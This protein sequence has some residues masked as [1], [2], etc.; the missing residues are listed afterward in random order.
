MKTKFFHLSTSDFQSFSVRNPCMCVCVCF[1]ALP[2]IWTVPF[3]QKTRR[4]SQ[5]TFPPRAEKLA[6]FL[7]VTDIE[8]D[9]FLSMQ[10]Q[11][12]FTDKGFSK[13]SGAHAVLSFLDSCLF[14]TQCRL[15]E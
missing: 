2:T 13:C 6:L 3:P 8:I 14:L 4:S 1:F 11:A 12:A 10:G 15:R 5:Y 9:M 7:D